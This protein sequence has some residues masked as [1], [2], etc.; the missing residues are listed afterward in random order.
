MNLKDQKITILKVGAVSQPTG[1]S[2]HI[3]DCQIFEGDI[4]CQLRVFGKP[5]ELELLREGEALSDL[6]P[7]HGDYGS[8]EYRLTN[9]RMINRQPQQVQA[10]KP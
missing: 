9:V 4:A 10:P 2:Y 8:G 3:R 7:S 5:E 6:T 1:K